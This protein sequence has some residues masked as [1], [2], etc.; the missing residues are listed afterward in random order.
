MADNTQRTPHEQYATKPVSREERKRI[1][2]RL[3]EYKEAW[4]YVKQ[5]RAAAPEMQAKC[6][7]IAKELGVD[8]SPIN[9]KSLNSALRKMKAD[10]KE[11]AK[12][13]LPAVTI[14]D[15]KD[16][17]RNTFIC[18]ESQREAVIEALNKNFKVTR[19]KKQEPENFIGY[20]GYIANVNVGG[21]TMEI[22]VVTPQM[23]YAK[24][25]VEDSRAILP[26]RIFNKLQATGFPAGLGHKYYEEHRVLKATSRK[27]KKIEQQSR[28]YYEKA[29]QLKI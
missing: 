24:M 28:E 3:R 20:Q 26:E 29:R 12:N 19:E 5:V 15:I 1:R 17:A 6:E 10:T 9:F 16:L 22:Q 4:S 8:V 18:D 11:N 13:E 7:S 2:K 27:A 14:R 21:H 25:P 23:F